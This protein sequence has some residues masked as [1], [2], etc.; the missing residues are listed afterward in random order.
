M[1]IRS[2]K[3]LRFPS[4]DYR[5]GRIP[6]KRKPLPRSLLANQWKRGHNS[7]PSPRIRLRICFTELTLRVVDFVCRDVTIS[8]Y[9]C[10]GQHQMVRWCSRSYFLQFFLTF[11]LDTRSTSNFDVCFRWLLL[12]V[13][14][15]FLRRFDGANLRLWI[16]ADGKKKRNEK[17]EKKVGCHIRA[18]WK[19]LKWC[20][21]KR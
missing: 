3:R 11:A 14:F 5:T 6:I 15:F 2:V 17:K 1:T 18:A 13:S 19:E 12:C 7:A 9:Q 4:T 21:L 16:G 8:L 10:Y 20:V